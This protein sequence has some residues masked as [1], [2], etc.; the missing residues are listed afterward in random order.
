MHKN[1]KILY[2][3]IT[4]SLCDYINRVYDYIDK[5]WTI[6]IRKGV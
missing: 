4:L 6:L 2:Y 3:L 1:K 5:A